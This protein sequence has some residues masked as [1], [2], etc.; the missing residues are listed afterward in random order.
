MQEFFFRLLV[1]GFIDLVADG[2]PVLNHLNHPGMLQTIQKA[3][4]KSKY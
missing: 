3:S 4:H 2:L 1:L